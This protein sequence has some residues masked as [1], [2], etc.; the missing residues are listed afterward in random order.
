M[1]LEKIIAVRPNKNIYQDGDKLIKV[2]EKDFSV[3]DVLNEAL[4]M[5]RVGETGLNIPK[6]QEVTTIDGKWVI[7]YD[8]I[9][10]N[11][12]SYLMKNEPDKKEFYIKKLIDVQLEIQKHQIPLLT[13]HYEKMRRKIEQT[14][15]PDDT[16]YDLLTKL[17][18]LPVHKKLCHGD[19][20][21]SNIIMTPAGEL[22]VI[23][24]AHATQGNASADAARTYL[25]FWLQG[26][27]QAAEQYLDLFSMRSKT[28]RE[29][30]RKWL[31]IVAATQTVKGVPEER[32]FLLRWVDVVDYQ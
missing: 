12:L 8:F 3:A 17:S 26:D 25:L 10:G 19:L 16:K 2:F 21:P 1:N 29:Y 24:W 11:S 15:L 7:V 32:E 30:I 6:L 5:A 14:S 20:C 18:S 9:E 23:D 4:N 27:P 28:D 31:P 22:F 13:K